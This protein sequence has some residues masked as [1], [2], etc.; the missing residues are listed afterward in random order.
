MR[1]DSKSLTVSLIT[2]IGSGMKTRSVS[3]TV[4]YAYNDFCVASMAFSLGSS[5]QVE[6]YVNRSGNWFNVF[7]PNQTS[8]VNGQDSGFVGF[9]QPRRSDGSWVYADPAKCSPLDD[10]DDCYLNSNGGEVSTGY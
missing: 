7:N 4:E 5:E 2:P 3:R 6:T 8:A 10:P 1:L 9:V